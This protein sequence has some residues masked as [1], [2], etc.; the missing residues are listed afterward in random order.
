MEVAINKKILADFR[1]S[2]MTLSLAK[3]LAEVVVLVVEARLTL[4][5][6]Q[7]QTDKV[8]ILPTHTHQMVEVIKEDSIW[9]AFLMMILGVSSGE[10]IKSKDKDKEFIVVVNT[11]KLSKMMMYS[12][13]Y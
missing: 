5:L 8:G 13:I 6:S 1:D 9:M 12:L 3:E 4:I 11:H 7:A 10:I 2:I